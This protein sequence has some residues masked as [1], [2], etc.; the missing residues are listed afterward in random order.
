[1]PQEFYDQQMKQGYT[2]KICSDSNPDYSL[3]FYQEMFNLMEK[4]HK[5]KKIEWYEKLYKK[6]ISIISGYLKPSDYAHEIL[7]KI[8]ELK[9][10]T[11]N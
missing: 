4:Y 10:D 5:V 7:I 3:P 9:N 11:K 8:N 2:D 6:I 1:M